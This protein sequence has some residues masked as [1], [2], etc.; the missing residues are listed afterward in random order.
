MGTAFVIT[1]MVH[2][3]LEDLLLLLLEN[4]CL[5]TL[6]EHCQLRDDSFYRY[7][8]TMSFIIQQLHTLM[9]K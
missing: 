4:F 8:P 6:R 1:S 7:K 5:K 2:V 9:S 3:L